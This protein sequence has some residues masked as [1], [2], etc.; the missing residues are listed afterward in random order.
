MP[1]NKNWFNA[2]QVQELLEKAAAWSK[3]HWQTLASA[4]GVIVV[5]T[6]LGLYFVSN[7]MA[8][9]KQ[10]WEKISY[11]QGY[12]SQGMTAQAIQIL[13][14]IIAKYSSSDVGQQARF[15]KADISY[16]TGTYNIAATVYQNIINVNRAKSMLPFAYAGLG[17]SK[18]NLGDYPGAISA[19][20]TFIEKYPNHY[21]AARVYDSLARVYLVTGSAESAKEMYEKLMTLY[22]GTYWSQQVQKNFAPPAQKQPVA[23][24]SREIPAPK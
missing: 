16:K 22:P 9:K 3:T 11:A 8:A 10:C 13:D 12:A 23:Q 7:Y 6:A 24:P 14:E 18:E 21:L 15:V 5:F 20:R 19:Y 17:Y 2:S 4:V 1:N